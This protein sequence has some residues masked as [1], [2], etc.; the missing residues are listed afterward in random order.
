MRYLILTF[1]I[2]LNLN[3]ADYKDIESKLNNER[4]ELNSSLDLQRGKQFRQRQ[5]LIRELA[6][7]ERELEKHKADSSIKG[8]SLEGY[9]NEI[10]NLEQEIAK[11]LRLAKAVDKT[12]VQMRREFEAII[13]QEKRAIYSTHLESFDTTP[14]LT[15]FGSLVQNVIVDGFE[16]KIHAVKALNSRAIKTDAKMLSLS[17]AVNYLSTGTE[18]G[19]AMTS[20]DHALPSIK[21]LEGILEAFEN[22][23]AGNVAT[24]PFDLTEGL[25]LK[26]EAAGK[27]TVEHWKAGGI[28]I[29]PLLLL[30]ILCLLTGIFKTFQLYKINSHYEDKVSELVRLIQAGNLDEAE[31][32]CSSLKGPVK[33]LLCDALAHHK[34]SRVNLEEILNETILSE[35]PALDRLLPIL[36][37]SAGAAPLLGLLGTVMGIIKTFEMISIYG[38]GEANRM[39]GGISEA[40]V[41]TEAGLI[42]AIPALIWYAVLNRRL[43]TIVG[44]LEKAMLGFI[45]SVSVKM[46]GGES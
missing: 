43:K 10:E 28:I 21:T 35:L 23:K 30:A 46:G 7:G 24:L 38:T 17:H 4:K 19:L 13:P 12:L 41:T 25:A 3:A 31:K 36:S 15:T 37:V 6:V 16:V 33:K 8:K 14:N 32:F 29:Y 5:K 11:N 40:L 39:A 20:P 26:Q 44:S 18:G 22:I 1:L 34:E 45:N 2:C 42:V 9:L 27:S